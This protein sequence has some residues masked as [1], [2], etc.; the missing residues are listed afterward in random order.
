MFCFWK[1]VIAISVLYFSST[2][3][4]PVRVLYGVKPELALSHHT[5]NRIG[6]C[7]RKAGMGESQNL[8]KMI[9]I[10]IWVA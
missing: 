1:P 9:D 10:S 8:K 2:G 7:C 3:K 6:A 4:R 5:G